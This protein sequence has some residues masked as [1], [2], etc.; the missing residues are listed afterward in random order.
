MAFYK[1]GLLVFLSIRYLCGVWSNRWLFELDYN[2]KCIITR[3]R[4]LGVSMAQNFKNMTKSSE[5]VLFITEI[6]ICRRRVLNVTGSVH[7]LGSMRW[8]LALCLLLSWMVCYF[9][10]W[11][12]VKSTGKVHQ[13]IFF[14]CRM[15][16]FSE[17]W[18]CIT[19]WHIRNW[20]SA[21]LADYIFFYLHE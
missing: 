21:L 14:P 1:I 13:G 20:I 15:Q 12:G 5:S 19:G 11:K 3:E 8:E 10:V 9:C 4:I 16:N 18:N 17:L 7:E 6:E 2:K